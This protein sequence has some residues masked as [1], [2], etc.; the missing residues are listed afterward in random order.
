VI[1]DAIAGAALD[2]ERGVSSFRRAA[3]AHVRRSRPGHDTV[4]NRFQF[5][6]RTE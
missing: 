4:D 6:L 3:I 1:S 5:R 2:I